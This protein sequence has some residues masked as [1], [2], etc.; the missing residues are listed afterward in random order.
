MNRLPGYDRGTRLS[1]MTVFLSLGLAGL[2]TISLAVAQMAEFVAGSDRIVAALAAP[3]AGVVARAS[4]QD[5][6]TVCTNIGAV[7][8]QCMSE[9]NWRTWERPSAQTEAARAKWVGFGAGRAPTAGEHS[10]KGKMISSD[11]L[12]FFR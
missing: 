5:G 3:Q 12:G 7:E 10:P 2:T 8:S 4:A 1:E 9:T 11:R 6:K